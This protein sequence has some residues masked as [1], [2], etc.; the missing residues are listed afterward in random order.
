MAV[1]AAGTGGAFGAGATADGGGAAAVAV[2][3]TGGAGYRGAA[4]TAGEA[5][6]GVVLESTGP[7]SGAES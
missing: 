6:A 5:G 4:A 2:A 3:G 7:L 1:A